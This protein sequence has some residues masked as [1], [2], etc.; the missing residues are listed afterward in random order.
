MF[1][2]IVIVYTLLCHFVLR[3]NPQINKCQGTWEI[4]TLPLDWELQ[5]T[6]IIY[7]NIYENKNIYI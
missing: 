1:T 6:G 5:I 3:K 4:D 7:L 2:S